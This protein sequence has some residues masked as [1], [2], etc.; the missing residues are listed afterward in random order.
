[1][2]Y[3]TIQ[4]IP[5]PA[6]IVSASDD[7][8]AANDAAQEFFPNLRIG[9]S[10]WATLRHPKM[11][12]LLQSSRSFKGPQ[13]CEI[14]LTTPEETYLQATAN[15]CDEGEVLIC[16]QDINETSTAIQMRKDFVSDLSHELRSPLTAIQAILETA[17]DDADA[18]T[19]FL[20]TL[21]DQVARMDG[22][23]TELLTLSRIEH[24]ARRVPTS[25]INLNTL[26]RSIC[27]ALKGKATA[28]NVTIDLRLPKVDLIFLADTSEITRAVTNLIENA[29]H[30]GA[31]GERINVQVS[32]Q[33]NHTPDAKD[34]AV[35]DII[36]FGPGVAEHHLPRLTER[37][38]RTSSHRARN[39]GGH[40]LG[41][42]IVKHIANRH[43]GQL[44]LAN[45]P[46][47]GF[48]ATLKLPMAG[49]A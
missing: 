42:A 4:A 47:G 48:H 23:A 26:V 28:A 12:D 38:Y 31:S 1:M 15:A 25:K 17:Q 29:L 3:S 14:R 27:T 22:L 10:V 5:L 2:Q 43:R 44:V 34:W 46:K 20:P 41:L 16:L 18:L 9:A 39:D 30:H 33:S 24:N 35:I 36:D 40:G 8:V 37:F 32:T 6:I 21:K 49:A 19:H 11:N 13:Q 45:N 7:I